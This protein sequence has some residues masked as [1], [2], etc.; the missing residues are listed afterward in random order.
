M[1]A[2]KNGIATIELTGMLMLGGV[3]DNPRLEAQINRDGFAV[4]N[5]SAD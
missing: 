1:Y 3:C 2:I 4:L 5:C